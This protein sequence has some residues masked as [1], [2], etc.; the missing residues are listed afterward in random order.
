MPCQ[1][2]PTSLA[3]VQLGTW[4]AQPPIPH[5]VVVVV[6]PHLHRACYL[7]RLIP[8][9]IL[10]EGIGAWGCLAAGRGS[11]IPQR[12]GKHWGLSCCLMPLR[13]HSGALESSCWRKASLATAAVSHDP[14]HRDSSLQILLPPKHNRLRT[15]LGLVNSRTVNTC[16]AVR[17]R[18]ADDIRVPLSSPQ[19]I[20]PAA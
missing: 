17:V 5:F 3:R 1:L 16:V 11:Y 18:R 7:S 9:R 15:Q 13:C 2:T 10:G 19:A 20:V 8:G 14:K 6:A 12:R 4:P